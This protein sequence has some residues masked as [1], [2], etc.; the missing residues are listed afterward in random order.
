MTQNSETQEAILE[1]GGEARGKIYRIK[2][3]T[4]HCHRTRATRQADAPLERKTA[5]YG[6]AEMANASSNQ[7]LTESSDSQ[8]GYSLKR[9]AY[10]S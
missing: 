8:D 7:T 3:V 1:N 2:E 10:G 4:G 6:T 9:I 5:R